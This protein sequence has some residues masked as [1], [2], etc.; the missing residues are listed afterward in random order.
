MCQ[1]TGLHQILNF[2]T[3]VVKAP[4]TYCYHS[5]F[6]CFTLVQYTV[7]PVI[8][9]QTH[10]SQASVKLH[11]SSHNIPTFR[12]LAA[13]LQQSLF[14]SDL[15]LSVSSTYIVLITIIDRSLL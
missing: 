10:R 12:H 1:M 11:E 8:D 5:Q 14:I 15:F 2:I 3:A 7:N 6:V 4:K 13:C 9:N